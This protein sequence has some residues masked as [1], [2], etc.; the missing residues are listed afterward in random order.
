MKKSIVIQFCHLVDGTKSKLEFSV[1]GTDEYVV[2]H[3]S[4]K[5]HTNTKISLSWSN[6]TD[7]NIAHGGQEIIRLWKRNVNNISFNPLAHTK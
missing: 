4:N 1:C 3:D 2:F 6:Y 5:S 7:I